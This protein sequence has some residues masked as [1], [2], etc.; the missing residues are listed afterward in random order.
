MCRAHRRRR[1]SNLAVTAQRRSVSPRRGRER[2][3]LRGR[4]DTPCVMRSKD[5]N[6]KV[7]GGTD[8]DISALMPISHRTDCASRR[9]GDVTNPMPQPCRRPYVTCPSSAWAHGGCG[10]WRAVPDRSRPR[11]LL[12]G[13]S[14]TLRPGGPRSPPPGRRRGGFG[15]SARVPWW[16]TGSPPSGW[17]AGRRCHSR[18]AAALYSPRP[19]L[20]SVAC[21][22]YQIAELG[23]GCR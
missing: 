7:A 6:E 14:R 22:G 21:T 18:A 2:P 4:P 5:Q 9:H 13:G 12:L 11:S 15:R 16:R 20:G 3:Y 10:G 1:P 17:D 8:G 23:R 19:V